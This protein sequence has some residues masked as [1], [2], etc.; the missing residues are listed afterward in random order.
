MREADLKVDLKKGS[1]FVICWNNVDKSNISRQE[2][3]KDADVETNN[4]DGNEISKKQLLTNMCVC[5]LRKT[6]V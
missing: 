5:K 1:W 6:F 3:A 4:D 2:Q